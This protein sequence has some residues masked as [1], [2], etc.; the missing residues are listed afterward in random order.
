LTFS[1]YFMPAIIDVLSKE[2]A[3]YEALVAQL[4]ATRDAIRAAEGGAAAP[5]AAKKR[6]RPAKAAKAEKAPANG[7]GK[8]RG[9][10]RKAAAPAE[11]PAAQA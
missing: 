5:A 6:G 1:Q 3:K 2:I 9:R 7:A 8:K 4:K 10:P 11:A